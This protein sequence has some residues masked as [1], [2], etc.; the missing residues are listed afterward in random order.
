MHRDKLFTNFIQFDELCKTLNTINAANFQALE[1]KCTFTF[2]EIFKP[3]LPKEV[4]PLY[5]MSKTKKK[6][7]REIE[8]SH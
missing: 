2:E 1:K 5:S 3:S 8:K 6:Y 4:F 7:P